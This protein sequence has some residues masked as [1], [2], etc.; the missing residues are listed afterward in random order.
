MTK[1]TL[2]GAREELAASYG[3][4]YLKMSTTPEN[5]KNI[6]LYDARENSGNEVGYSL[7]ITCTSR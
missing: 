4:G 5:K 1:V 3:P 6:L 2:V 7:G